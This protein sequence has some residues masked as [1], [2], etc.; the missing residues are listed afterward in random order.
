MNNIKN[1]LP[2]Y[3]G[4][5]ICGQKDENPSTMNVRFQVTEDGVQV[6][7]KPD[8]T[9]EGY[10]NIV[11]GGILCAL[12]DETIGWAAAVSR[13]RFFMTMELNVKFVRPVETDKE[14]LVKGRPTEHKSRYSLAEGEIVD[15][16]G[17][18]YTKATGKFFL[19]QDEQARKVND[20]LEYK[21]ND[22]DIFIQS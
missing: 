6:P 20:Y 12:L 9:R 18:V 10:K 3:K 17:T 21:E 2:T 1:Y 8:K 15:L 5:F 19:M 14:Y 4:C 16:E 7:F 22:L 11:H 13:Q